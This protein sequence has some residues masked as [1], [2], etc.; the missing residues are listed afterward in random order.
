MKKFNT[1][2]HL[3]LG[4]KLYHL[5]T[6]KSIG[7]LDGKAYD[8]FMTE[9]NGDFGFYKPLLRKLDTI[10]IQEMKE[11]SAIEWFWGGGHIVS[12]IKKIGWKFPNNYNLIEY[13]FESR[14]GTGCSVGSCTIQLNRISQRQFLFLLDKRFDLFNLIENGEALNDCDD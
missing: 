10:T 2:A 9:R 4:C 3:Y 7:I 12:D 13:S 11:L 1:V 6:L 8:T 5:T 14:Q